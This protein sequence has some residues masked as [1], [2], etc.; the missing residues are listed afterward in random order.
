MLHGTLVC[1]FFLH[2]DWTVGMIMSYESALPSEGSRRGH[3]KSR[4]GC[5][6]C[7]RRRIKC[8]ETH[9]ICRK[10]AVSGRT[11]PFTLLHPSLPDE[12]NESVVSSTGSS[13]HHALP[14]SPP[15]DPAQCRLLHHF[16]TSGDLFLPQAKLQAGGL[17]KASAI[18]EEGLSCSFLLNEILAFS[19]RHL[20]TCLPNQKADYLSQAKAYQ[21]HAITIFTNRSINIDGTNC[22]QVLLFSWLLGVH[23]L[24][25]VSLNE[26]PSDLLKDFIKY[27]VIYRGVRTVATQAWQ[28]MLQTNLKEL[29]DDSQARATVLG[30]GNK[31][32]STKTLIKESL[33]LDEEQKLDCEEAISRLEAAFDLEG[34]VASEDAEQQW[35]FYVLSWPLTVR[36][37]FLSATESRRPEALIVIAHYCVLLHWCREHWIVGPTGRVLFGCVEATLGP[38][39]ERWMQWP[40]SV[41]DKADS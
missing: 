20:A 41:I 37:G 27:L 38:G 21:S 19:A 13:Q 8:D 1:R 4:Y 9:P 5:G 22:V 12:E 39:W 18:I 35:L 6:E 25:D 24:C 2:S 36:R 30:T 31:T 26:D 16:S 3:R 23:Q 29:L 32:L 34:T 15:A 17:F 7:K 28:L 11:C 14:W 33:G 40:K 10:C